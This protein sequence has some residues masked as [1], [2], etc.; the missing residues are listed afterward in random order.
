[1]K[2]KTLSQI[3]PYA[4]GID[5]GTERNYVSVD[6]ETIKIFSSFTEGNIA[7]VKY[8]QENKVKTVAMEST[9]VLWIPLYDLI[10]ES[11]IEVYLVNSHY[12]KNIPSQKSD[13]KDARWLQKTHSFGLLK[14]SIIPEDDIREMRTYIRMRDNNIDACSQQIQ[15]MQKAFELMNLKLHNVISEIA[16]KSGIRIIEA[17]LSG[18]RNPDKLVGLCEKSILKTKTDKVKAS[19]VG[20]YQKEYLFMLRQSYELYKIFQEKILECDKELEMLLKRMNKNIPEPPSTPD[21]P[22]RH[23]QPAIEDLHNNLVKI[24]DGKN[25]A[26]LP[27][28]TDKSL[29]KLIAEVGRDLSIWET[30]KDFVSWLGLAPRTAQSG[31]RK[32]RLKSRITTHAGQI[33]RESAMSIANSKHIALKGFYHRI[34]S[35]HGAKVAIKA[36]AR[37]LAVLFYR[38]MTKGLDYVEKGLN[39][40]NEQYKKTTLRILNKKAKNLGYILLPVEEIA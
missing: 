35:K 24:T 22:A 33:F 4:A 1:M 34:K 6:G 7:L 12:I 32:W 15:R 9:G 38:F 11:G 16:G 30:E 25:A 8:L 40:Y 19:L 13:I 26:I 37:K 17:I 36:T 29:L 18:E 31:K 28:L 2:G 23:N 10:E 5:I 39:A 3:H 21:K 14:K 20:N 27:G